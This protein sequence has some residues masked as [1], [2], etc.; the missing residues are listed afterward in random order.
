MGLI[1]ILVD[2]INYTVLKN[3]AKQQVLRGIM[4]LLNLLQKKRIVCTV[5]HSLQKPKIDGING[6]E[7]NF[8]LP[9][10]ISIIKDGVPKNST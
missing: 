7:S 9:S 3:V 2:P 6:Q 1:I 10:I 4:F 8:V 5:I